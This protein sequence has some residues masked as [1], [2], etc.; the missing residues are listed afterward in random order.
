MTY[1]ELAPQPALRHHV[2]R[3]WSRSATVEGARASPMLILPDGCIDVLLDL[4]T[5]A[6]R[7]VG[8]MT[9]AVRYTLPADASLVAA[10]FRP[11][12]ASAFLR[13]NAADLTDRVIGVDELGVRWLAQVG[14]ESMP[15]ARALADLERCLLERVGSAAIDPRVG[16]AARRLYADRPP[17]IS[18]LAREL[19]Q[20]RQHLGRSFRERV[21][22]SPKQFDRVARLQRAVDHL[23][24]DR[25]ESLAMA[26]ARLGYCDQAHMSHDF[27]ELGGITPLQ[28]RGAKG[29]ISPIRS[30]WLEA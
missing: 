4:R 1:R 24:S 14:S 16:Y 20:T 10:R 15:I 26:A 17:R 11:G 12:A 29:S 8:T 19:G 7:V 25:A 28:A 21:G 27:R 3:L 5:G 23:Q 30:L 6:T 22:V 13:V 2:D 18:E 9:R